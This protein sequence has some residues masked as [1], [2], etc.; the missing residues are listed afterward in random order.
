MRHDN[1]QPIRCASLEDRNQ[2]LFAGGLLFTRKSRALQPEWRGANARH[3]NRGIPK[4][5]ST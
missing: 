2:H 5:N 1:V 4:E 3:C